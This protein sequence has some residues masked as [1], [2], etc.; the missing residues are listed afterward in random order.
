MRHFMLLLVGVGL[1]S[2]LTGC[3]NCFH[4]HGICDCEE[5]DHCSSRSPWVHGSATGLPEAI[6]EPMPAKLPDGKK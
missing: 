6:G 4:S 2:L 3:C 1:L 5:D